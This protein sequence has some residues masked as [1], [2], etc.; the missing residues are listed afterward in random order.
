TTIENIA[1][2]KKLVLV[3]VVDLLGRESDEE[4]NKILFYR[5]SDGTVKKKVIVE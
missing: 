2:L 3:K 1:S 4:N 5:Y